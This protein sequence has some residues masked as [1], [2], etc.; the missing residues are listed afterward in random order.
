V[1]GHR[2]LLGISN[3]IAT[4]LHG[5][6]AALFMGTFGECKIIDTGQRQLVADYIRG[7]PIDH[8][9]NRKWSSAFV[10][11]PLSAN[12]MAKFVHGLCD[13]EVTD[14]FRAWDFETKPVFVAPA[15][16]TF[17]W[18]SPITREQ[19]HQLRSRG[20]IVLDPVAK[21]LACGDTGIGAMCDITYIVNEVA[22]KLTWAHPLQQW[23]LPRGPGEFGFQ[24]R[25]YRH[26]GVDLYCAKNDIVIA[27]ETGRV[28]HVGQ[29]TG[30][31]GKWQDTWGVAVEGPSGVV[32]YGELQPSQ[33]KVGDIIRRDQ[34]IGFVAP[35][36]AEDQVLKN[37][38]GHSRYMLHLELWPT[39]TRGFNDW[40]DGGNIP[41]DPTPYLKEVVNCPGQF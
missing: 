16:N 18:D 2:I 38:P 10:V 14:T 35:V 12:T 34:T 7:D 28:V 39:G 30:Q 26:T 24:R 32:V 9:E 3:S 21:T 1:S 17:M 36:L 5:K 40:G 29:F 19:V 37:V 25:E 23:K 33:W 13:N 6:L 27:V 4:T 22:K 41:I 20:V 15:M 31:E 11:A 8:I